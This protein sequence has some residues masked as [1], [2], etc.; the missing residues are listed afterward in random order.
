[1]SQPFHI[2]GWI[3]RGECLLFRSYRSRYGK[4]HF[5]G[6]AGG[7]VVKTGAAVFNE[8]N[9]FLCRMGWGEQVGLLWGTEAQMSVECMLLCLG[10]E[11]F[12]PTLFLVKDR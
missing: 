4:I 3:H 2:N 6:E 9:I 8:S 5:H 11:P 7:K 1:M 12:T 10:G